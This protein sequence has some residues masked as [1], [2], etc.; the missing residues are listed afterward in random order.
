MPSERQRLLHPFPQRGGGAGVAAF[1]LAGE[2]QQLVERASV[3]VE[4]PRSPQP[5]LRQR[6]VAGRWF[7]HV[8]FLVPDA[9]PGPA[10]RRRRRGSRSGAPWRRRSRTG[11]PCSGS[12]PR[13]TRPESSAVTTFAFSVRAFPEPEQDLDALGRDPERD[14]VGASLQLEPVEHHAATRRSS[15][16]R[17]ISSPS[18]RRVRSTNV[19]E[20][21][22]FDVDRASRSTSLPPNLLR[23]PTTA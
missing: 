17:L 7:E 11:S 13:S 22:D 4:R 5:L 18:A 15:R 3:I 9:P 20:T 21:D 1:E 14:D 23:R 8:S 6:P 12:R 19:R 16:R 2:Q 10:P